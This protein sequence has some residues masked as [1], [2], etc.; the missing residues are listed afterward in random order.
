MSTKKS[1]L[2]AAISVAVTTF[3]KIE[4]EASA[5]LLARK[6]NGMAN[7]WGVSARQDTMQLRRFYQ[8]RLIKK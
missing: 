2:M 3:L 8:L 4:E 6:P 1:K 7:L 5:K